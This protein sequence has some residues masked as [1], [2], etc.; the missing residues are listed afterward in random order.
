MTNELSLASVPDR[1]G[2][3]SRGPGSRE[4][5]ARVAIPLDLHRTVTVT[6]PSLDLDGFIEALEDALGRARKARSLKVSLATFVQILA[7]QSRAG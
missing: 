7:D 5:K 2:R 1:T 6:G 3:M 4:K